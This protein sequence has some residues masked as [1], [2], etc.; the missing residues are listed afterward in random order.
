MVSVDGARQY[1][2]ENRRMRQVKAY[3]R[4][5]FSMFALARKTV[6]CTRR[7]LACLAVERWLADEDR[8]IRTAQRI[9][10]RNS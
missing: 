9:G 4:R 3:P 2:S 10:V 5:L 8:R 1:I 6:R 7:C